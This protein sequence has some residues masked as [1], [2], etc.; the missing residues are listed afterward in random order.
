MQNATIKFCGVFA[1]R[2]QKHRSLFG[3]SHNLV[4]ELNPLGIP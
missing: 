3:A 1:L 4:H 2:R